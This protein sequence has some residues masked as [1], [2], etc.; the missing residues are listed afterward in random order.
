VPDPQSPQS[1]VTSRL[2]TTA[3][4]ARAALR[5]T[6]REAAQASI[7]DRLVAL[8]G[9]VTGTR[10]GWYLPTDGEVD[11]ATACAPLRDR[12]VELLLPVIG[13]E[14][15]L[16]FAPWQAA[17]P[18]HA[19]RYGIDEPVHSPDAAVTADELD[20]VVVPCVAVDPAGHR[21]GFG[22]GYYDRALASSSARR[23]GVVFEVQVV[24]HLEPAPWDVPLDLVLTEAQELRAD[25]HDP[26]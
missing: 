9:L 15:S 3:R 13:P 1:E 14:R 22:A 5:G 24:D 21:I 25:A 8:P 19:N 23:I 20:A 26:G 7:A 16:R 10:L 18:L 2:R 17:T 12:G 4:A 11:L 6:E